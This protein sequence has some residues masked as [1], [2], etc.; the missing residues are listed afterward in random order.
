MAD[1]TRRLAGT[2]YLFVDGTSYMLAGDFMYSPT[3]VERETLIG[4]DAVHGYSE[5]PAVA[6]VSGKIRDSGGLKVSS[7]NAMSDVTVTVELANGKTII[8]RNA[9][10]IEPPVVNTVDGTFDVRWDALSVTEA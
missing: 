10:T 1:T 9:W 2:A 3:K 4:M 7:I 8:A 5:K 6:Y